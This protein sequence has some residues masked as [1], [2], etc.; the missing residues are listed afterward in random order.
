MV[1][2]KIDPI[3]ES[4]PFGHRYRASFTG[5]DEISTVSHAFRE[6]LVIQQRKGNELSIS[7]FDRAV[8]SWDIL[9]SGRPAVLSQSTEKTM[10]LHDIT[11]LTEVLVGFIDRT[12]EVV[13][14]LVYSALTSTLA[15]EIDLRKR[16][17]EIA[18]GL[19][20]Y[21]TQEFTVENPLPEGVTDAEIEKDLKDLLG[22]DS[23]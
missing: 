15:S 20:G 18:E 13:N 6:Q 9:A 5:H 14:E 17:A 8:G 4:E 22:G 11:Y 2:M 23:D 10:N 19:L 7:K 21:I 3:P 16:K 12:D 1:T